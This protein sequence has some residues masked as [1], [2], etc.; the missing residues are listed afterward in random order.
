MAMFLR[1]VGLVA[2]LLCV[3]PFVLA[4]QRWTERMLTKVNANRLAAIRSHYGVVEH[5]ILGHCVRRFPK[6]TQR[7]FGEESCAL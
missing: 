2:M 3:I 5:F 7:S 1:F 4:Q 6:P